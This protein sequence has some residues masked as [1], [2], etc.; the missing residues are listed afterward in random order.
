MNYRVDQALA[1]G[2]PNTALFDLLDRPSETFEQEL[3][4]DD[5][6]WPPGYAV[7]DYRTIALAS[8][9]PAAEGV[10]DTA[11]GRLLRAKGAL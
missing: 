3:T 8:A 6:S 5:G 10:T 4:A 9:A 7:N 11:L 2:H 1:A